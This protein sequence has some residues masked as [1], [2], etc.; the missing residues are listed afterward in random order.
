MIRGQIGSESR[1][2]SKQIKEGEKERNG[3]EKKSAKR[4]IIFI[5]AFE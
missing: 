1:E 3:K 4:I 5:P 2:Q